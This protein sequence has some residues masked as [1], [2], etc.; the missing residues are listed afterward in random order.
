MG[1]CMHRGK[2]VHACI[3]AQGER[4]SHPDACRASELPCAPVGSVHVNTAPCQPPV[5]RASAVVVHMQLRPARVRG[6]LPAVAIVA[7]RVHDLAGV[8]CGGSL[9]RFCPAVLLPQAATLAV[10]AC[11][12]GRQHPHTRPHALP[13]STRPRERARTCVWSVPSASSRLVLLLTPEGW[14]FR[15]GGGSSGFQ[16]AFQL[17]FQLADENDPGRPATYSEGCRASRSAAGRAWSPAMLVAAR[18]GGSFHPRQCP[19]T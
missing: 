1:T 13:R 10:S 11:Q 15:L 8:R 6:F 14:F 2:G 16:F 9:Y 4:A 3:G 17:A 12:C 5:P 19:A 7:K 18:E